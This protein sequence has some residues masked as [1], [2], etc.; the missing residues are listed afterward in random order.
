VAFDVF[1]SYSSNDKP[2]ADAACA[3]LEAADIRC[4]IAPRDI[5][6]GREYGESIIDAIEGAK[7][8]VLIFSANANT[9]PQISREVERAVS[10]GLVIVPVRIEDVA[11]SRNLEYFIS[12]PHWL[13]AFPPPREKYFAKLVQSVQA[14]L[15]AGR[16]GAERS[17]AIS[18]ALAKKPS[19]RRS[20]RQAAG[21]A[22]ALIV[23][24]AGAYFLYQF[25]QPPVFTGHGADADSISFT[26][27]G[28]LIAAGGWDA[29]IQIWTAANGKQQLPG[30]SGFQGHA[31]PFSPDGTTIAGGSQTGNNVLVWDVA[32][33]RVLQTFSGPSDK[34]QSV[35]FSP[36]GKS[37]V[38]GGNDPTIFIWDLSN[39]QAGRKLVGHK[40]EVYSVAFSTDGKRI[41]SASFDTNV[42]VWD[43]ASGQ[44][45]KT[46]A[47]ANKMSAAIFSSDDGWLA[48]AGWDGNVTV[49]DTNS[50]QTARLM[51]GDGQIVTTI[52]FSP[53]NKLLA[54]G[55]YDNAVK[56]WDTVTGALVR[57][58]TGHTATVWA[59]GFSP[60]G[61]W[62]ASASG[63]KTV[64]LW[65]TP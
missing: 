42:I 8:F 5:N 33:R 17:P 43:V 16:A 4:W 36:D 18:A 2:T 34:V 10:K 49:W 45:L 38:S 3:A 51:P 62:I 55:G 47:G 19:G 53:D 23:V 58:F 52:A 24:A 30:I 61:K 14:L 31:A 12:S 26:P 9:S 29:S 59:V 50:W 25:L 20:L 40:Q 65:K 57:T 54:S 56:V 6:P 44:P 13:D 21:V 48:T 37:L 46:L 32:S 63:D 22:A 15:A 7:V 39:P 60:D 11:P 64:R 41:A 27:D 1:I 28:K 35:A